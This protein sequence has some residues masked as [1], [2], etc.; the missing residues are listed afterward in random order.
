MAVIE[1]RAPIFPMVFSRTTEFKIGNRAETILSAINMIWRVFLG[2]HPMEKD[3][4][5]DLKRLTF[6]TLDETTKTAAKFIIVSTILAWEDEVIITMD[7]INITQNPLNK[8]SV[9]LSIKFIDALT[10]LQQQFNINV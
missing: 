10:G 7:D 6:K 3:F 1:R 8:S 9:Q 2:E 5:N 4:G